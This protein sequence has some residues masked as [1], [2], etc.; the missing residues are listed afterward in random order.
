MADRVPD[1]LDAERRTDDPDW[2]GGLRVLAL[3]LSL[4]WAEATAADRK[5]VV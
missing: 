2:D 4:R 5:S 1:W 3:V